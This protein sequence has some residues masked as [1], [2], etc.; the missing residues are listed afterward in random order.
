MRAYRSFKGQVMAVFKDDDGEYGVY[1]KNKD[2]NE[3][4]FKKMS[5]YNQNYGGSKQTRQEAEADMDDIAKTVH[6]G[7]WTKFDLGAEYIN[8]KKLLNT[9][10]FTKCGG[11]IDDYSEGF[12]DAIEQAKETVETMPT[13]RIVYC[14]DCEFKKECNKEV[15][16]GGSYC[17]ITYCSNGALERSK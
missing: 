10:P 9:S 13:E 5:W 15:Y 6:K 17:S 7:N 12:L 1:I 4:P 3:I 16:M 2:S 8:N 11:G 14:K